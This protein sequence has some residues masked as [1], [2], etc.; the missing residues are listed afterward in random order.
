MR[1]IPFLITLVIKKVSKVSGVYLWVIFLTRV[2]GF[3]ALAKLLPPTC[4]RG[5]NKNY[6]YN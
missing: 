3:L 4:E 6:N 1:K 5:S 2:P